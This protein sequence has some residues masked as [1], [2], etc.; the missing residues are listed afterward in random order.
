MFFSL[1]FA[2]A[3]KKSYAALIFDLFWVSS[4]YEFDALSFQ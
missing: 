3:A 1:T 2:L 4:R